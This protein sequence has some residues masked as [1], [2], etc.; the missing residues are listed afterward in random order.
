M[1]MGVALSGPVSLAVTPELDL[2]SDLDGNGHHAAMSGVV[3]VGLAASPRLSL[4]AELWAARDWDPLGT[5]K[6]YS[7]DGAIA[8]LVSDSVAIDGGANFGLNR[9][10]PDV[11]L[12]AGVS[13]RF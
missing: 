13:A 5:L 6:Q 7:A 2:R 10:T 3:G 1:P 4:S 8:Y 11:E 12:Y 9:T